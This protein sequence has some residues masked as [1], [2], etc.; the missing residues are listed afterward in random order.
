M[1]EDREKLIAMLDARVQ[2]ET[3]WLRRI[4]LLIGVLAA[5]ISCYGYLMSCWTV[6][7]VALLHSLL[8]SL[9]RP[10]S[11]FELWDLNKRQ[12]H[13]RTHSSIPK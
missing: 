10:C 13:F 12:W 11:G 5:V 3:R 8:E 1:Q 6:M 2:H 7:T 9:H 4:P